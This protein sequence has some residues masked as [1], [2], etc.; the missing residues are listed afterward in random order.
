MNIIIG[1][2]NKDFKLQEKIHFVVEAAIFV[3]EGLALGLDFSQKFL[4]T[5]DGGFFAPR[6]R[7]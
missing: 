3:L 4:L 6:Q 5:A 1:V 7:F 2:V